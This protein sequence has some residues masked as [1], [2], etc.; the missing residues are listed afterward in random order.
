MI[1]TILI[2]LTDSRFNISVR[3]TSGMERI[4]DVLAV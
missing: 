1:N 2:R 3:E 4:V